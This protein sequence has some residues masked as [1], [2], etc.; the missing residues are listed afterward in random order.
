[1]QEYDVVPGMHVDFHLEPAQVVVVD[2]TS[3]TAIVRR[4]TDKRL[5]TAR[6]SE[7]ER[8]TMHFGPDDDL[9]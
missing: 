5:F 6:F 9:Y 2:H 1:M 4:L 8:Q 7:L 3:H